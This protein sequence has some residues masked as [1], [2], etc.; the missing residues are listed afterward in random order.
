MKQDWTWRRPGDSPAEGDPQRDEHTPE[1][2][3]ADEHTPGE[4]APDEQ[5]PDEQAPDEQTPRE[6]A[7]DELTPDEHSPDDEHTAVRDVPE[8]RAEDEPYGDDGS[9]TP[10]EDVRVAGAPGEQEDLGERQETAEQ[11]T[12]TGLPGEHDEHHEHGEHGVRD[13]LEE[14]GVRDERDGLDERDDL[15]KRDEHH[16][17]AEHGVLDQHDRHDQPEEHGVLDEHDEHGVLD[18]PGETGEPVVAGVPAAES[19][20]PKHAKP[21]ER[22]ERFLDAGAADGFRER[23]HEVQAGFVDDPRGSVGQ[24]DELAGELINTLVKSL[25]DRKGLLDGEWSNEGET[26]DTERLRQALRG[27]RD[28]FN[29]VLEL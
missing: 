21:A 8:Q 9:V 14:P 28:L 27:Y 3:A 25:Q 7:A 17:L 11:R 1:E 19:A 16:Q 22:L 24:A 4:H 13:E 6:H 5:A 12:E 2:T 10:A 20:Q 23:W 26:P 18:E 15:D 29:R